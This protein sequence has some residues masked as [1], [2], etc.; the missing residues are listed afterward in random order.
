M[1]KYYKRLNLPNKFCNLSVVNY[2]DKSN[3]DK[4][5]GGPKS[6]MNWAKKLLGETEL[7]TLCLQM[8]L[9]LENK[10]RE[11]I[12][13]GGIYMVKNPCFSFDHTVGVRLQLKF[14][15]TFALLIFL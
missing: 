4:K 11:H 2:P 15:F 13:L 7:E 9:C 5:I 3:F 6:W 1:Q 8:Y 14:L 12:N 10:I